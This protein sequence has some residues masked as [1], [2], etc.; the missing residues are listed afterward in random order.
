MA[1]DRTTSALLDEISNFERELAIGTFFELEKDLDLLVEDVLSYAR[2]ALEVPKL[3]AKALASQAIDLSSI[4]SAIDAF[5]RELIENAQVILPGGRDPLVAKADLARVQEMMAVVQDAAQGHH[6]L[7]AGLRLE[8]GLSLPFFRLQVELADQPNALR[9]L[10]VRVR[11]KLKVFSEDDIRRLWASLTSEFRGDP[12]GIIG[13]PMPADKAVLGETFFDP[14][15]IDDLRDRIAAYSA[16]LKPLLVRRMFEAGNTSYRPGLPFA[17]QLLAAQVAEP[18]TVQERRVLRCLLK[19]YR[20]WGSEHQNE[21]AAALSVVRP[22]WPEREAKLDETMLKYEPKA[23]ADKKRQMLLLVLRRL[24]DYCQS[25]VSRQ[26]AIERV[27]FQ[28]KLGL[29]VMLPITRDEVLASR[30]IALQKELCRFLVERDVRAFG[31]LFGRS[32]IDLLA[33]VPG[34]RF[35]IETKIV[36][37]PNNSSIEKYITQLA[38]YMDQEE[39]AT[40]GI[41]LLYNVSDTVILA[42]RVWFRQKLWVLPVNLCSTSPSQTKRRIHIEDGGKASIVRIINTSDEVPASKP[43]KRRSRRTGR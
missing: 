43:G 20:L 24:L 2:L 3:D 28:Y 38:S 37:R 8:L 6:P 11:E 31:K 34:E 22:H 39:P 25:Y 27:L 17:T 5:D 26:S 4:K 21:F 40:R 10:E 19:V 36:K 30:E 13:P 42:E 7:E 41:L 29:E 23:D 14:V 33:E 35:L 32:E 1:I 18:L 12:D 9:D 15:T 16:R